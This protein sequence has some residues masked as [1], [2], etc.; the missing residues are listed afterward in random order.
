MVWRGGG[1]MRGDRLARAIGAALLALV[2]ETHVK[3]AARG[4]PPVG[5]GTLEP[6]SPTL[7][8]RVAAP[9][10]DALGE[11]LLWAAAPAAAALAAALVL[12]LKTPALIADP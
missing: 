1:L 11:A 7:R 3:M 5:G 4:M 6:L 2:L 9:L 12:A 10:G 8:E